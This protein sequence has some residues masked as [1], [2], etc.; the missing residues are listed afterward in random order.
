MELEDIFAEYK[1][2]ELEN[3]LRI[4][5]QVR[6]AWQDQHALRLIIAVTMCDL[7]RDRLG[8]ARDYYVPGSAA[9][10]AAR[11]E[12]AAQAAEQAAMAAEAAVPPGV[13]DTEAARHAAGLRDEADAARTAAKAATEACTD[14]DRTGFATALEE[15][16][17]SIG[18][19]R[20]S[21]LAVM[22]VSAVRAPRQ[23]GLDAEKTSQMDNH[24]ISGLL[25]RFV[26]TVGEFCAAEEEDDGR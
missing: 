12:A 18:L 7:F 13:H 8:E 9:L 3:F 11:V 23:F 15:L 17:R 26:A 10:R 25:D 22:P 14:P 16:V 20:F 1:Q 24:E 2:R 5:K 19:Q 4:G 21:K 6:D